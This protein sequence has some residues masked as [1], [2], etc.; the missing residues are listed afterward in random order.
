MKTFIK[1]LPNFVSTIR[2]LGAF[3]ILFIEPLSLGFFIVYSVCGISD[4]LD[5]FLARIFQAQSKVGSALDSIS[6]LVFYSVMAIVIFPTLFELLSIGNWIV[7]GIPV[8]F[9]IVG[10]I[11]CAIKFKKFSSVHTYANKFLSFLVFAFPFTFIGRIELLYNLYIYIGSV[12]AIYAGIEIILIHSI[13]H[14]YDERNKM[15]YLIKRNE[16]D[17]REDIQ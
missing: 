8:L 6:D 3:T 16:I 15:V 1:L 10:Y 17:L 12:F 7:I 13:A 4:V 14:R 11:L 5:G 9:Q 2:I